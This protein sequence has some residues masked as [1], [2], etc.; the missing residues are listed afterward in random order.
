MKITAIQA[1]AIKIPRDLT[2]ARGTAG[3]PAPL[4]DSRN[5][6]RWA[7]NYQTLYSTKIETALIKVTTDSGSIG[8]GE[9][10]SPVAPE[11]VCAIVKTI[12][13]PVLIGEDPL[14]HE[15]LWSLMYAT[16]RARPYELVYARC[17]CRH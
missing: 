7:T 15:K 11:I 12:L 16:M 1:F 5:D 6:Y 4:I 14:A 17:D 8:W 2:E 9:A 13:A 3:S 10:Q